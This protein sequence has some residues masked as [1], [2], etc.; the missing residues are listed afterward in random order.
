MLTGLLRESGMRQH[1]FKL[2][3]LVEHLETGFLGLVCSRY[4]GPGHEINQYLKL[5][6][7]V[8]WLDGSRGYRE[9]L[10]SPNDKRVRIFKKKRKRK[11]KKRNV[12]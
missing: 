5:Y 10:V 4:Y 6:Y 12:V 8:W 11:R 3:D 1:K 2:G 7:K 9:S